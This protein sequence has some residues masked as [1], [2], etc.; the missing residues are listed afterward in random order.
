[1]TWVHFI[2]NSLVAALLIVRGVD[3]AT[4]GSPDPAVDAIFADLTKPGSPGCALGIYRDGKIIYAKG[5]GLSN[6]E[7]SVPITPQT[8]FDVGSVSKQFTAASILLLERQGKLRLDDDVHTYV[9]ELPEYSALGGQKITILRLLNHTSGV[10]DYPTLFLLAGINPDNVTTDDDAMGIIVRQKSMTFPPGTDWQYSNSGYFLLSVIVKRVSGKTLKDFAAEN[11]FRPL[12][13]THTQFRNDHT[14]LIPHRALAYDPSW[15]GGYKLSMPYA[16]EN[17]DGM[18]QTSIEDLQ[19]WDENFYSGQVGGKDFAT[20]LEESGKLNDG[21]VLAYAKG[22]FID[23]YRGLRTVK[24]SGGSGGYHAYLLRYPQQHFSVACLC[25]LGGVNRAKRVEAIA[26]RYLREVLQPRQELLAARLTAEQLRDMAGIYQDRR[27]GDVWRFNERSGKLWVDF[28]GTLLELR[29]VNA[30][31]FEPVSYPMEATFRFQTAHGSAQRKWIIE[32]GGLLPTSVVE[33]IQETKPSTT[34][35]AD[36][37]GDYWSDDLRVTYRLTMKEGKLWMSDL[38]GADGITRPGNV[39]FSEFRPLLNDTFDLEGA[40]IVI[41]FKRDHR[42][43]VDGFSLNG[44]H[45]PG[46]P[47]VRRSAK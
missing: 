6:I 5:Y 12:G 28:D 36:Y 39:P 2:S 42:G 35:L 33:P 32:P 13:M 19:K 37:P 27:R 17:G 44:F 31:E 45:E 4:E 40:P 9:P 25:N 20:E 8:V 16:E 10:R 1:M 18:L 22:L 43:K 34:P 47:F 41:D 7:E 3:L 14:A 15:D 23:N 11:I 26:D 24:H 21:T 46:I 30:T 29:A 38:I